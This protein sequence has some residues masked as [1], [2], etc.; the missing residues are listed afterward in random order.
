MSVDGRQEE[1]ACCHQHSASDE[2]ALPPTEPCDESARD[3]CGE[4]RADDHRK[5]QQTCRSGGVA[6]GDLE[7]LT[8]EH[9]ATEQCDTH[10]NACQC[11]EGRGAVAEQSKRND[12]VLGARFYEQCADDEHD[13]ECDESECHSREP[14]EAVTGEGDPDEQG[15]DAGRDQER[16]EVVDVDVLADRREIQCALDDQQSDHRERDADVERPAPAEPAGVDDHAADQWASDGR[17]R[18]HGSDR[19]L[20]ASA[21]ARAEHRCDHDDDQRLQPTE[22]ETLDDAETDQHADRL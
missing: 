9:G 15:A 17:E 3:R 6:A 13:S 8:E 11:G 12:W 1:E 10:G 22:S 18:H 2:E 16:A 20:V 4:H 19:T 7:V 14:R 5:G 21:F